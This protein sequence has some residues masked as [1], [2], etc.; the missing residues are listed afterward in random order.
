[1]KRA[2]FLRRVLTNCYCRLAPSPIHGIGVFAIRDIPRGWKPFNTLPK[3]A[4]L[5]YARVATTVLQP[6]K[7]GGMARIGFA[8]VRNLY[9][10]ESDQVPDFLRVAGRP[11]ARA[12]RAA[13][14]RCE[15]GGTFERIIT[16]GRLTEQAGALKIYERLATMDRTAP[17]PALGDQ[18]LDWAWVAAI[19]REWELNQ[20]AGR[21][22][23]RSVSRVLS[24]PLR[25]LRRPPRISKRCRPG[26]RPPRVATR[27]QGI[28]SAT[29]RVDDKVSKFDGH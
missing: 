13:R 7:A 11:I 22:D 6:V 9:G 18:T 14:C 15:G 3:Y 25:G 27:C 28:C 10:V 16:E 26:H 4:K 21:F 19:D 23:E 24:S 29:S 17:L 5:G 20:L 8:Q 2:E 1:M 12:A